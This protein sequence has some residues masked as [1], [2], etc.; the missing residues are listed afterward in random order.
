MKIKRLSNRI[1]F[2]VLLAI[3]VL[4]SSSKAHA[5]YPD[6][7]IE[8]QATPEEV[9]AFEREI[10]NMGIPSYEEME[11]ILLSQKKEDLENMQIS[12]F[13]YISTPWS[14]V[15]YNQL[16]MVINE[17]CGPYTQARYILGTDFNT[18][19]GSKI[20]M[21]SGKGWE[22]YGY[23]HIYKGHM[24]NNI[25]AKKMYTF[26]GKSQFQ[27]VY[28]PHATIDIMKNVVDYDRYY[29]RVDDYK[30]Y[31]QRDNAREGQTVRVVLYDPKGWSTREF[32]QYDYIVITAY[33][34]FFPK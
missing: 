10:D 5:S 32:D 20:M 23:C 17:Q 28:N 21:P 4:L 8:I 29:V 15:P 33:P 16:K 22:N 6:M 13:N 24:Q 18:I 11:E 14:E 7:G 3:V 25:L 31:K 19:H 34:V 26:N 1:S 2:M 30:I 9:Q 27:A 12:T